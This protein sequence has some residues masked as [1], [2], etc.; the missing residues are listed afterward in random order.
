MN[1]SNEAEAERQADGGPQETRNDA[2]SLRGLHVYTE[3]ALTAMG[4]PLSYY[5]SIHLPN[6]RGTAIDRNWSERGLLS[7]LI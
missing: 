2:H 5:R 1:R 3:R 7:W 4:Y 6:L